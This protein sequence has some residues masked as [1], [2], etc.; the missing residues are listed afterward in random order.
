MIFLGFL[1]SALSNY[2]QKVNI[3]FFKRKWFD[4]TLRWVRSY[5]VVICFL[6][7]YLMFLVLFYLVSRII[8]KMAD[9][10][11]WK[12]IKYLLKDKQQNDSKFMYAF[13]ALALAEGSYNFSPV[14]SFARSLCL[15]LRDRSLEFFWYFAWCLVIINT[16]N[17]QSRIFKK[18]NLNPRPLI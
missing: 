14:R 5:F 17:W 18:I 8:I 12:N 16:Q 11:Y 15:F 10:N 3:W 4:K 2:A 9:N 1:Y 13:L 7:Q 6:Y